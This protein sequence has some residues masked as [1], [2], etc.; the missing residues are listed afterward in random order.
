MDANEKILVLG[1]TGHFGARIAR[2]LASISGCE[3]IITSRDLFR[4][5]VFVDELAAERS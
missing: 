5:E 2:R 3:L 4:A 1:G